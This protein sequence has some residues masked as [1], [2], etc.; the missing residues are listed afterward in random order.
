V[1]ANEIKHMCFVRHGESEHHV[2]GLTGGWTDT[3]LTELGRQQISAT[4]DHFRAC[5]LPSVALYCSD[6]QRAMES[7]V[8]M[9]SALGSTP[10]PMPEL[11]ELNN[12]DTAGLTLTEAARIQNPEPKSEDRE[13]MLDWR[14][15]K[16]AETWR[17]MTHRVASALAKIENTDAQ[18]TIIV[19]HAN[20]GQA[21]IQEWLKLPVQLAIAFQFDPASV[22]ELRINQWGEREIVRLNASYHT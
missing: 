21:L 18:A 4:A 15:Y 11:R 10:V 2:K 6:L 1:S 22:T 8:I 14:P 13:A 3:R 7:A 5:G 17:E 20:S 9:G 16:D 12:G 19:G